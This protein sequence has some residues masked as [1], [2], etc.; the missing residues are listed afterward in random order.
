[1]VRN[2][3]TWAVDVNDSRGKAH[4]GQE[5]DVDYYGTLLDKAWKEIA[6]A[7]EIY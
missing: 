3:S 6:F 4:E 2:S 1:V 5:F 7:F